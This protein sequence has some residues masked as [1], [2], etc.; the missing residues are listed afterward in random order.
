VDK[1]DAESVEPL[2]RQ[3]AY[4]YG[5]WRVTYRYSGEPGREPDVRRG[6]IVGPLV[7]DMSTALWIAVVPDGSKQHI[8]IRRDSITDVAPRHV[9]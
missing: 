2:R 5:Q 1:V 8:M 7:S 3:M 4:V 9:R 6:L